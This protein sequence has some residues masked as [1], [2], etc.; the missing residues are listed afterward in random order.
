MHAYVTLTLRGTDA[1]RHPNGATL[2][3]VVAET[4]APLARD[5]GRLLVDFGPNG[6]TIWTIRGDGTLR[7]PWN[8]ERKFRATVLQTAKVAL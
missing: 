4:S 3:N 8:L 5:D 7:Q 6:P 2:Q 1:V